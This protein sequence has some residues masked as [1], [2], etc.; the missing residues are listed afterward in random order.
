MDETV[1]VE[2]PEW[3]LILQDELEK[4]LNSQENE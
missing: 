2:I 3:I 4:L 1:E